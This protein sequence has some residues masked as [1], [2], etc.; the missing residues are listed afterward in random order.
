M[1]VMNVTDCSRSPVQGA[2]QVGDRA[3][4]HREELGELESVRP[5]ERYLST[6]HFLISF[7]RSKKLRTLALASSRRGLGSGL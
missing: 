1:P 3:G 7:N 4:E 5:P 6:V 2:D